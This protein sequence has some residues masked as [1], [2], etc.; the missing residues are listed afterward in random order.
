M[1]R[2]VVFVGMSPREM[3]GRGQVQLMNDDGIDSHVPPL[4]SFSPG[5]RHQREPKTEIQDVKA[6]ESARVWDLRPVVYRILDA[7]KEEPKLYG[8]IAEEVAEVDPRLCFWSQDSEGLPQ[9]EGVNY[10][11]VIPLLL[12][13]A[14][15]LKAAREM[16][17]THIEALKA[18]R[19]MDAIRI[20]ALEAAREMDAIR[21]ETLGKK[22][23][24]LI[25]ELQQLVVG[26]A[27]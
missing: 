14:K 4:L 2:G 8:F 26:P 27:K 24:T 17:A 19:E 7:A 13:E 23:D 21:I 18:A 9:V 6:S 20:E 15:E 10:D 12:Q 3:M 16:D 5:R 25:F 1:R 11:Q 22:V